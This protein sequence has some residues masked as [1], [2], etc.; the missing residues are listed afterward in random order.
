MTRDQTIVQEMV[1][2]GT[3]S[4]Q[5]AAKHRLR[6]MLTGAI[7]AGDQKVPV[8][9]RWSR[10][11]DGDQILLCTDGLTEM[12]SDSTIA[13]VLGQPVT[14]QAACNNL[15]ELALEAGGKD[16]VSVVLARYQLPEITC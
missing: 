12:V 11:E 2:A 3:L 10:L 15:V 14:A 13:E 16:N 5:D 7:S 8:E 6:H 9:F 1:D 4:P